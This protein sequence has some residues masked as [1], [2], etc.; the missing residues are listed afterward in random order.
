MVETEKPKPQAKGEVVAIHTC[1][2]SPT[3]VTVV[4]VVVVGSAGQL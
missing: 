3:K 1:P 4:A 2:E